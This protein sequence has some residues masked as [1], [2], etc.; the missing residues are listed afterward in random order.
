MS[1]IFINISTVESLP[2]ALVDSLLGMEV[3]K[4]YDDA[5][6][7]ESCFQQRIIRP[8]YRV[9]PCAILSEFHERCVVKKG[10]DFSQWIA[11]C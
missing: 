11:C 1:K 10:I 4:V 7:S 6:K 5:W 9:R 8:Q 3:G 2:I